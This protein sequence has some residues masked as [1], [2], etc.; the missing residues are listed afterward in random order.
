MALSS[1]FIKGA[2]LMATLKKMQAEVK[3]DLPNLVSFGS[4]VDAL[5]KIEADL[6]K[7]A[8]DMSD[9]IKAYTDEYEK[10]VKYVDAIEDSHK[11][12]EKAVNAW[13]KDGRNHGEEDYKTACEAMEQGLD[14][15]EKKVTAMKKFWAPPPK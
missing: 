7:T 11:T 6:K 14:K 1:E 5:E 4:N 8:K 15:I 10:Y 12:Y 2:G 13:I 9:A 3:K